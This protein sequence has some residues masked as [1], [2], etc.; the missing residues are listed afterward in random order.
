MST[1]DTIKETDWIVG[2]TDQVLHHAASLKLCKEWIA[3]RHGLTKP[4]VARRTDDPGV[5]YIATPDG[6]TYWAMDSAATARAQGYN[7]PLP[8]IADTYG[9][10]Q[11]EA[12]LVEHPTDGLCLM[13]ANRGHVGR[14]PVPDNRRDTADEWAEFTTAR[15]LRSIGITTY[16]GRREVTA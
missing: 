6:T 1:S 9:L 7:I 8:E 3:A 4:P 14:Q 2:D 11:G 16:L 15:R 5:H 10:D 12:A 13:W